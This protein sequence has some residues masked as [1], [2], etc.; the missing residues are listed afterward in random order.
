M[1]HFSVAVFTREPEQEQVE[2]LL[3]PY[4][5]V[6]G[7]NSEYT[8][9]V[10]DDECDYQ[11]ST[12]KHG[13]WANPNAR[14]DWYSIGGGWKDMLKLADGGKADTALVSEVDCGLNM[15]AYRSAEREWEI[16]VEGADATKEERDSYW[17]F[18]KP[19]YYIDQYGTKEKYAR[20]AAAFTT[21]AFVTAD[22]EWNETGKMG[23]WGVDNATMDSRN[24][25]NLA[26]EK[27][28]EFAREHGLYITIVDCHI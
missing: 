22:G 26:F 13:Y 6:F 12:G 1:S 20:H 3:A 23:W 27:Y 28:L 17:I 9:F 11:E 4:V 18:W 19:Q 5:E 25:Y 2:Q 21:Y 15:E 7:P 16:A 10:E 14:W 8:E 24:A